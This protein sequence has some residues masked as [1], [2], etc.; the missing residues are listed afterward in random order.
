M[1]SRLAI[2]A[3]VSP[4][5]FERRDA[6]PSELLRKEEARLVA[7]LAEQAH[8]AGRKFINWPRIELSLGSP[9]LYMEPTYSKLRVS[10][11]TVP[12]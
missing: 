12:V 9:G 1:N 2:D 7:M 4:Y 3:P 10:V 8:M 6:T 11:D 5:L